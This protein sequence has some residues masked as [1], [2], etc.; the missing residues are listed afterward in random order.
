VDQLA[1]LLVGDPAR[2]VI[3]VGCKTILGGV[4]YGFVHGN[5]LW[6]GFVDGAN[7]LA[8]SKVCP[9]G[10]DM[11]NGGA[12]GATL[13]QITVRVYELVKAIDIGWVDFQDARLDRSEDIGSG[14]RQ[15]FD[16]SVVVRQDWPGEIQ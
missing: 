11:Q 7:S 1:Y 16:C 10:L 5:I 8:P 3:V 14:G 6:A 12:D 4:K 15:L 2:R 9:A 13:F